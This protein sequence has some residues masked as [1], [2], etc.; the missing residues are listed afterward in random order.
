M[1]PQKYFALSVVDCVITTVLFSVTCPTV[2]EFLQ[3]PILFE[4]VDRFFYALCSCYT[5][6]KRRPSPKTHNSMLSDKAFRVVNIVQYI[7]LKSYFPQQQQEIMFCLIQPI[8][9]SKT[10]N[11][12]ETKRPKIVIF[13]IYTAV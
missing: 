4:L 11:N 10:G 3:C 7:R 12:K 2:H 8:T 5:N 9:K 13:I 1:P 6:Y